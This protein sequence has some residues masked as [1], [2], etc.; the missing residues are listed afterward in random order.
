M[1]YEA[2]LDQIPE[3]HRKKVTHAVEDAIINHHPYDI[4]YPIVGYRDGV[5]RW[6]KATGKLFPGDETHQANF[7]GTILD[8]TER[9]ME[10]QRKQDF[11]GIVSH[12][13]KSPLTS[14]KGYLQ[15]LE[16]KAKKLTDV[17]LLHL[18]GK[19]L[20][21]SNK[22][23]A[24]IT[25]FLDVARLGNTKI[26]LNL[27]TFDMA[28]LIKHSESESL[29]TITTHNI[30]YA[31]VKAT[32]VHADQDKIEQVV[33]NFI[34]NA[35]KYSPDYTTINVACVTKGDNALVTVRDEGMGIS[36]KD[37]Q[38]V[39]DRF[40][41]AESKDINHIS[42]FGIGLYICQEIIHGHGGKIGVESEL[43]KGS[44]FWFEL[45]LV[46]KADQ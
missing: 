35:A 7:S 45:P 10:E 26:K 27:K 28:E 32:P 5:T 17:S 4:E 11:I 41:R 43:G 36:D 29:L 34:N 22:M 21:Q 16:A 9:K 40:Y 42:G 38:H 15:I 25:G 44:T 12:E 37:K 13:L 1:S 39:F 19:A 46:P 20:I 24:L 18:T 8:I 30:I 31:P 2:A 3:D 23:N 6:V 33:I 14:L